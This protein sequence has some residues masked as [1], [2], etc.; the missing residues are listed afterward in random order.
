MRSPIIAFLSAAALV[1]VAGCQS[2]SGPT[3]DGGSPAMPKSGEWPSYG[4]D[5]NEQRFSP[6]S[7]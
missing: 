4:R 6:L 2:V 5:Y 3:A 1:V 7:R